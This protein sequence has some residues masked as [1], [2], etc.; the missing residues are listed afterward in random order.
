[1]I[2]LESYYIP[3]S[4]TLLVIGCMGAL[5]AFVQSQML[6][7]IGNLKNAW[8]GRFNEIRGIIK[9]NSN[10]ERDRVQQVIIEYQETMQVSFIDN[11]RMTIEQSG[12]KI[13]F[14]QFVG[15]T[16]ILT[17]FGIFLGT[18]LHNIWL[19]LVIPVGLSQITW[20]F[21][22]LRFYARQASY[23]ATSGDVVEQ[24]LNL[25]ET[26]RDIKMAIRS[27]VESM[28]SPYKE[29]FIA[30]HEDL[31]KGFP[32]DEA[33]NRMSKQV[34]DNNFRLF[35]SLMKKS[36]DLGVDIVFEI[37]SLKEIY[38]DE[39]EM[40]F[41]IANELNKEKIESIILGCIPVALLVFSA[42]ALP[43]D[44]SMFIH[45][46]WINTMIGISVSLL[47]AGFLMLPSI[48]T[49]DLE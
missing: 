46:G 2:G 21:I 32:Y 30:F 11:I 27:S 20:F 35:C 6:E 43:S 5:I 25:Y 33:L 23:R 31:A 22:K 42:I 44:F 15:F 9:D 7:T 13:S 16:F 34:Q 26:A 19:A 4:I 17:T 1:M 28:Q 10:S 45:I 49:I 37:R 47:V 36:V 38:E 29:L 12:I 14:L 39:K 41:A 48:F 40:R 24:V 3:L 8:K 18:L